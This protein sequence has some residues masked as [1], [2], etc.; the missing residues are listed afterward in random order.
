MKK[1]TEAVLLVSD[2]KAMVKWTLVL[3]YGRLY[4]NDYYHGNILFE[5]QMRLVF[6]EVLE[7]IHLFLFFQ[8]SA[9]KMGDFRF[10][11]ESDYWRVS[12]CFRS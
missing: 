11:I 6:N 7:N 10:W 1:K 12:F 2:L 4:I 9:E 8:V 3:I 5:S